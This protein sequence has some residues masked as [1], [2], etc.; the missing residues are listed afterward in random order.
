MTS[1]F[2]FVLLLLLAAAGTGNAQTQAFPHESHARLFV[3]CTTCHA[4]VVTPGEAVWPGAATCE[5]CHDGTV[6]RRVAWAP[7]TISRPTNIRFTHDAHNRVVLVRNAPDSALRNSCGSCHTPSGSGR[8][9]VVRAALPQCLSCHGV[10]A[11]HFDAPASACATCHVPLTEARALSAAQVAQFPR[12]ASHGVAGFATGGHGRAATASMSSCATCHARNLCVDCHVN[13]RESAQIRALATDSRVPG[14]ARTVPPP[15]SHASPAFLRGH[16]K[17][18]S[19]TCATCHTRESCATCHTRSLPRAASLLATAAPDRAAGARTQRSM[20]STHSSEFVKRQ[21]AGDA[22]ARP[23]TCETC[24][25]RSSCLSCHR[26]D[27]ARQTAYHPPAFITR[28][29]ALVYARESNC[30]DC[31]NTAQ[32]CQSCHQKSG[33]TAVARL[34]RSGYHDAFRG[35]N[36]GHGQAARQS[37][38]TCASCHA[39]RDCTACH[40]AVGAGFRFSPHGPGFNAERMRA[41]NPSVCMAC[42]GAAVPRR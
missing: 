17:A 27:P 5:S 25:Q 21:H 7:R 37:L 3:S 19:A 2:A 13:T 38:E 26:P 41:K 33:L 11:P 10:S 39:E 12:P 24:H 32:F 28:H 1:R 35:F 22:N 18:A 16:G 30:A 40:S 9:T 34:G 20:P 4:G 31:H 6:A 23:R 29:P 8:M 42:H 36:L 14:R 15:P